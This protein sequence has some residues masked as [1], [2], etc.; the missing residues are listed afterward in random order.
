VRF[1]AVGN[2]SC[3]HFLP[4]SAAKSEDRAAQGTWFAR[5]S[6]SQ[7]AI[8]LPVVLQGPNPREWTA[9]AET[10]A[11]PTPPQRLD[12]ENLTNTLPKKSKK[13]KGNRGKRNNIW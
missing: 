12:L 10:G 9:M 11:Q 1:P 6:S 3:T 2:Y 4:F 7:K 8:L 5:L 13:G